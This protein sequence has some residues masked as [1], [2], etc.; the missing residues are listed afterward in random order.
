MARQV[1]VRVALATFTSISASSSAIDLCCSCNFGF[2]VPILDGA[3]SLYASV[4]L[5]RNR[6]LIRQWANKTIDVHE[7]EATGH[8]AASRSFLQIKAEGDQCPLPSLFDRILVATPS[9]PSLSPASN[10]AAMSSEDIY[11]RCCCLRVGVVEPN[12]VE[13]AAW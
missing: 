9:P 6:S 10:L 1:D 7:R 11:V 13:L 3:F 4:G 8:E 5:S 12:D 2:I